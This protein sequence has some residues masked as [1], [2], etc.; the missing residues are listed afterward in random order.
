MW[1]TNRCECPMGYFWNGNRCV[2]IGN[3][4]CANIP[5]SRWNGNQCVCKAN[6]E[7]EY[8]SQNTFTCVCKGLEIQGFCDLCYWRPFSQYK[9]GLCQ[10]VDGY[11]PNAQGYC[12]KGTPNPNPPTTTNCSVANYFNHQLGKCIRCSPGCLSCTTSYECVQ[13]SPDFNYNP[14]SE[15]CNEKCGDGKRYVFECDDGNNNNFDGCTSDCYVE[16]GYT[17]RGGSPNSR[18]VCTTSTPNKI[19]ITQTGQTHLFGKI[20]ANV[21]LNYLPQELIDQICGSRDCQGVLKV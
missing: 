5:N 21:R 17:C 7:P 3:N 16:V 11:Y 8:T 2:I 12:E 6:F 19:E 9:N 10:C 13:C 4:Q 20:I 15:L 1:N 18:D 14:L